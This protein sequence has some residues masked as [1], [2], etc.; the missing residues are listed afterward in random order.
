MQCIWRLVEHTA[1]QNKV[2][3]ALL[4]RSV[5]PG[6]VDTQGDRKGGLLTQARYL[7]RIQ[8]APSRHSH[9]LATQTHCRPRNTS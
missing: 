2:F 3:P 7:P 8:W 4:Y 6:G 9:C 5:S 1:M